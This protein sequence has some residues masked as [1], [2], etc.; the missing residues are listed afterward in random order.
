MSAGA[1]FTKPNRFWLSFR[2]L[3]TR[4]TLFVLVIFLCGIWVLSSVASRLM[5]DQMLHGLSEL[6]LSTATY[7]AA[8]LDA[9]LK[10]RIAALE[11]IASAI[12]ARLLN[13]PVALQAFLNQRLIQHTLFNV[14]VL[15]YRADSTAI[16]SVPY[17]QERMGLKYSERDYM[18]GALKGQPTIGLPIVG[19]TVHSPV[20]AMAVPIRNEQGQVIGVVGGVTNL[21][22]PNY[23]DQI[24]GQHYGQT[25]GYLVIAPKSRVIVTGTD[26]S[27]ILEHLPAPGVNLG[28]DHFLQ[29]NEGTNVLVNP[30]GVEVVA[31]DKRVPA[32]DWIL[33]VV[34]PTAEAFAPLHAMQQRVQWIT[35]ALSL[36]MAAV[37]WGMLRQ[38][39]APMVA[40]ANLL[41]GKS[42]VDELPKALPVSR[43]DEI[44]ELIACFNRVLASLGRREEEL[45]ASEFRWKFAIEGSGDGLWDWDVAGDKIFFN[46]RW[47]E[48]LG[49][50]E[51]EL[52][53]GL[54]QWESRVHPDDK[55]LTLSTLHDCLDGKTPIYIREHRIRC[56]DGDYKWI[57]DRGM[58]VSRSEDGTPLRM[59]G[60]HSDI[61]ERK[62]LEEAARVNAEYVRSLLEASLDPMLTISTEGKINDVNSATERVTGVGRVQLIGSDFADYFTDPDKAR[63]GYQ[64]VFLQG[65]V[66]DY[67]LAI[68]HVAGKITEVLYNASVY[69][70]GLGVVRGV[71]AAARDITQLK[72]A[73][74]EL[75]QHRD[76]LEQLVIVRTA[77]L[78][79]ARLAAEAANLAKSAF[80]ANMSHEIRT[81]MNA[82]IGLTHLLRRSGTTP[83]H[84]EWLEKIDSAGRHLLAIINDILDISKIEAGRL[85]LES[86][87]FQLSTV[88]DNVASILGAGA[89]DKGLT[90][91]VDD[92]AVPQWL[93]GDPTR[94]RQALL[95]YGGNA[96]KFTEKGTIALRSRLLEENGDA[97]FVR[98]EVADTG[99]GIAP[100][101][102]G[103]LFNAFEQADMS[104]TRK[105]GGTGL[106]LAI[107][108]H[109]A[110][111]MGGDVG[112]ESTPGVGST[113]WFTV[114]LGHGHGP[115]P[116]IS[117][118]A[119]ADAEMQLRLRHTGARLLLVEDNF[120]NREV[121][122][123]I[124]HGGGLAVDTAVDGR[125]AVEK[126]R[127]QAY[128]LILMDIQMPNMDGLEASRAIRTLPGWASK[129]IVAMTANVF[130]ED[131][132]ACEAAGMNDFVAKPVDPELLYSVLLKWLP[133]REDGA[134]QA[135]GHPHSEA[136]AVSQAL[137]EALQ[138]L[139]R[140]AGVNTERGLAALLGKKDKYLELIRLFTESHADDMRQLT[141]SL[142]A[143]DPAKA[144]LLAHT[145]KGAAATLGVS[146]MEDLAA[147]VVNVLRAN[148]HG[149][150]PLAQ[151]QADID[152]ITQAFDDLA[153]A[154]STLPQPVAPTEGLPTD[155]ATVRAVLDALDALLA[156]RDTAAF[157]LFEAQA[158]L[159]RQT[160]GSDYE[161]FAHQIRKVDFGA[162]RETLQG[163]C[164]NVKL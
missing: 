104:T 107:T 112:V 91:E 56:K 95:N 52:G 7:V 152:A 62:Q 97:I 151:V 32:A 27:R 55:D 16:A 93:R 164:L 68:R 85:K 40:T 15:V 4:I 118:G 48:I 42:V 45:K 121:A 60:T 86:T 59:I 69:R 150:V 132:Q 57:L 11:L 94:L 114:R 101:K 149:G 24:T 116:G 81:P 67:P 25:G 54:V 125:E 73:T 31:A 159:L 35:A 99:V 148:P 122:V 28:I 43:N 39:F 2:S 18:I 21:M 75:T 37:V 129:P 84:A 92:D 20:L 17:A 111:L 13:N 145:L 10:D 38:Q 106:G 9:V 89:R 30:K 142:N 153:Q 157:S 61:T 65:A 131:R 146:Q 100:E 98:F 127:A 82:I 49:F 1:G 133:V 147:K 66:T 34:L 76:K 143:G 110:Q 64:Q 80:L 44:G 124:L 141:E 162:A 83:E 144:L 119:V 78:E 156:Q 72:Q 96:L 50:A 115:V 23:L 12:D 74:Q 161:T 41:S 90:I 29:G 105:Y 3:K 135:A 102:I 136:L 108:R 155:P 128:D 88:L 8:Q 79:K 139:S 137:D 51:N 5:R 14:G 163:H 19:K 22:L 6:Q 113:F 87:D 130:N 46:E 103:R 126:A 134:A 138:R 26:K 154:L 123:E 158:A 77:E 53:N 160:L 117:V 63:A 70:D 33:A 109:L 120:I 71:F 58:V 36:L 47:K 140:R